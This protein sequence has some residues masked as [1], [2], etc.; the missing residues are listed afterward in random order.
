MVHY[1]TILL[2]LLL[3]Q[4][5]VVAIEPLVPFLPSLLTFQN[6][7]IVTSSS[8]WKLRKSEVVDQLSSYITGKLPRE[9]PTIKS[10]VLVNSTVVNHDRNDH[11]HASTSATSNFYYLTFDTRNGGVTSNVS[12]YIELLIPNN[13]GA[14]CPLFLTQWNH[15]SWGVLGLSRGYCSLIYPGSDVRDVAPRFQDAYPNATMMLIIARAYVASKTLDIFFNKDSTFAFHLPNINQSQICITG[16]S[17]NGKQSLLAAA[18][19]ERFAAVVGSSPGAPIASPYHLSSHNFYGEGPDAG[20]AGHWW[21]KSIEQYAAHPEQFPVDGNGVLAAIAPRRAAIANGWTDHEGDINFADECN[22]RSA[23]E[24]YKLFGTKAEENLRVIHRPGDHHGF[25]D[26]STYFDWF[27]YGF[28]RLSYDFPLSWSSQ[29]Q[30]KV[31]TNPFPLTYL[32]PA[33]FDWKT[34]YSAFGSTTLAPP[35]PSSPVK[36]RVRWLIQLENDNTVYSKGATYAED[37]KDGQFRFPS[38]MMG[39]DY[40]NWK[41]KYSISRQ[42]LSFGNYVTGN[43]FWSTKSLEK[44]VPC[45]V[46][47][48]LHPYSYA[49]GYYSSYIK[50]GNVVVELTQAGYCVLAYDQVGMATRVN[51]GGTNFYAR[52]GKTSSLFGQMVSDAISAVDVL[53]CM[54]AEGRKDRTL[55]GTGSDYT[56]PYIVFP[57][58]G[59]PTLDGKQIT[60]AG[61]SLGGNVALHVAALDSRVTSVASFSGFTPFR[62]DFNHNKSTGGIQRLYSFHALIPRLGLFAN[63]GNHFGTYED[64]PYDYRELL[65]S[66]VAPRPVLILT[67]KEDRDA[68]Y[69]DVKNCVDQAKEQGWTGDNAKLFNHTTTETATNMG[70]MEIDLFVDWL[71]KSR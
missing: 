16:H 69:E 36:D 15:R 67:A 34:W 9:G 65:V 22:V 44:D 56:G 63:D 45:P 52:S 14:H 2:L 24:V 46:V 3:L 62:T 43:L 26:V 39:E 71:G 28:G 50:N 12:Y 18:I 13:N 27:D 7:S 31:G 21:L 35:P 42:P 30:E 8:D 11:D 68:T 54:T 53:M 49:T 1:C 60:L 48:W 55:C 23:M 66:L 29:T 5:E 20:Q 59:T 32:T 17:R 19:D 57:A 64:I 70:L 6:G 40:E 38:V 4:P 41:E 25:D 33:G 61:Y 51:E 37:S 47:V 58:P 10:C